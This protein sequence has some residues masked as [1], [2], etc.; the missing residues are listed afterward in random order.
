M[1]ILTTT[2]IFIFKFSASLVY[3]ILRFIGQLGLIGNRVP[4]RHP[5]KR[6]RIRTVMQELMH[7]AGKL[8]ATGRRFKFRF[9][10]HVE[11]H[12]EAFMGV[13]ERLAYG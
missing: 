8:I 12:A 9:S 4:I 10:R 3:N 5:V 7:F 13:Y 1:Q 6:R 2:I 11:I